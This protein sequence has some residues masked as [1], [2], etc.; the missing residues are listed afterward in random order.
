MADK[1][2]IKRSAQAVAGVLLVMFGIIVTPLPIPFGLLMILVGLSLLASSVPW[3]RQ[4]LKALRQRY[5]EFSG[6][7]NRIKSKLPR[8]VRQLIEDTDPERH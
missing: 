8:F 5:R 7:L 4:Y 1:S 2:M 3:V 6:K